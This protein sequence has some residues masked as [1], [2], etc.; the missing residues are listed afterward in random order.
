MGRLIV[1]EGLDGSGKSTQVEILRKRLEEMGH[2]PF[3][4][5][6]PYYSDD[7]SILVRMYLEGQFG[8]KPDDVNA[9]AASTFYAADRYASY[10]KFWGKEYGEGRLIL[11]DRYTTSN[12]VHQMTKLSPDKWDDYMAWLM[13]FEYNKLSIP[14]P[15][16][17]IFLDM[18]VEISQ[19]LM[20]RRYEGDETKKDVHE[21]DVSYLL[22]CYNTAKYAAEKLGWNVVACSENGEPRNIEAIAEDIFSLVEKNL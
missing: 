5:K 13:D 4:I 16:C 21:R 12:A 11:A 3:E 7:S 19:K 9:Y 10:K 8:S 20:S 17:V 18:P 22:S 14:E 1:I 6:L 15:D 2:E